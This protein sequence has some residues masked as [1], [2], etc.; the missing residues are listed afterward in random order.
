MEYTFTLSS[1]IKVNI[2]QI[3]HYF[4]GYINKILIL[5]DIFVNNKIIKI[6]NCVVFTFKL[7]SILLLINMIY[8]YLYSYGK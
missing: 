2:L 6:N 5:I 1:N 7:L 4:N 3:Y 8:I